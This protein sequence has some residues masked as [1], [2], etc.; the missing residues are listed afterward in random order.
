MSSAAVVIGALRVNIVYFWMGK[1]SFLLLLFLMNF[2]LSIFFRPK[3]GNGPI[4]VDI[5]HLICSQ[6]K[7]STKN[8]NSPLS[9]FLTEGGGHI[10]FGILA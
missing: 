9:V 4:Q 1:S 7:S 2:F 3:K 6:G 5:V 8:N 10:G